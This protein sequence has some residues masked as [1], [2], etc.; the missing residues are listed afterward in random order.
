MGQATSKRGQMLSTLS[1]TLA[2]LK[3]DVNS[4]LQL[5][6]AFVSTQA[7]DGIDRLGE[8]NDPFRVQ[9]VRELNQF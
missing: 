5:H 9:C 2:Q 6:T 4:G 1:A 8:F 7:R 3:D